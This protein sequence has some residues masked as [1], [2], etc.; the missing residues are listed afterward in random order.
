MK[1]QNLSTYGFILVEA[2][3]GVVLFS[4]LMIFVLQGIGFTAQRVAVV[5]HRHKALCAA[6]FKISDRHDM[7][8][9][10][11]NTDEYAHS[12]VSWYTIHAQS[13]DHVVTLYT[14]RV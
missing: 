10:R 5:A 2:V 13:G 7:T 8:S 6:V 1:K 4:V 14:A 9:D 3:V 12:S 11:L